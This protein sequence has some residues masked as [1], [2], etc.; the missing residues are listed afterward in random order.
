MIVKIRTENQWTYL[1]D[2]DEIK[3]EEEIVTKGC[4]PLVTKMYVFQ[5]G[6]TKTIIVEMAGNTAYLLNDEGKTIERIN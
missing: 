4:A 1:A 6:N 2:V 5:R 3:T